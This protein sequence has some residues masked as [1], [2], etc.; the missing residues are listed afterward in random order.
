MTPP[1][2]E[3]EYYVPAENGLHALEA[4]QDLIKTKRIVVATQFGASGS[5]A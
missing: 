4:L 3:M 1:F 5:T 2:H